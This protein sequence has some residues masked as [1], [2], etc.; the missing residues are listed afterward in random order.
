M[1]VKYIQYSPQIMKKS[2]SKQLALATVTILAQPPG[3][4]QVNIHE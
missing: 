2:D 4:L 1:F 3:R